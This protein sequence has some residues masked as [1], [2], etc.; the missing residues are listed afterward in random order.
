MK[1]DLTDLDALAGLQQMILHDADRIAMLWA[2]V[3]TGTTARCRE[4]H[5]PKLQK[6]GVKLP[7]PLRNK[8]KPDGLLNLQNVDKRKLE[9]R[10]LS[11][12]HSAGWSL[13]RLELE[14]GVFLRIPLTRFSGS[15]PGFAPWR[16]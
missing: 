15:L 5:V 11:L 13:K 7:V 9:T 8:D 3:P 1:F 4:R 6:R 14:C 12:R 2:R 16:A 10:T